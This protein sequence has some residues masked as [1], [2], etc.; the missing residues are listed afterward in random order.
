MA[1]L[2]WI[3]KQ[4]CRGE[5]GPESSMESKQVCNLNGL[6]WCWLSLQKIESRVESG[7]VSMRSAYKQL[8]DDHLHLHFDGVIP[9]STFNKLGRYDMR[10]DKI[11]TVPESWVQWRSDFQS[12]SRVLNKVLRIFSIILLATRV[13]AASPN[14]E[15]EKH[16]QNGPSAT[17]C[18]KDPLCG[19]W[20]HHFTL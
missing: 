1:S 15:P 7:E 20:S 4:A 8:P 6:Q 3:A 5:R 13:L 12:G 14:F 2:A 10:Y 19:L 17:F 16:G 9:F 11:A 18:R